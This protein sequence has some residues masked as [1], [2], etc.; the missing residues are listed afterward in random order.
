MSKAIMAYSGEIQES[1]ALKVG[2][3]VLQG[4]I[5][6]HVLTVL[7]RYKGRPMSMLHLELYDHGYVDD[8]SEWKI[9]D[10]K[11]EHLKDPTQLLANTS[12]GHAVACDPYVSSVKAYL[13]NSNA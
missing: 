8:W 12:W 3:P 11:P 9:G 13:E 6:G 5:L 4:A 7:R 10:P 2:D 1:P